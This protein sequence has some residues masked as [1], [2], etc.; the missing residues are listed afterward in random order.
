MAFQNIIME[1]R[2]CGAAVSIDPKL[3]FATCPYCGNSNTMIQTDRTA[4]QLAVEEVYP[5][6]FSER[7]FRSAVRSFLCTR[8][9]VPDALYETLLERE[10]SL[11]FWPFYRH[12][13]QW[14]ANW[15]ADVGYENEHAKQGIMWQA[16][17]G[18]AVGTAI[19]YAPGSSVI[20]SRG[21]GSAGC[22]LAAANPDE[23]MQFHP[24]VFTGISYLNCDIEAPSMEKQYVTPVLNK[25]IKAGCERQLPGEYK[26]NM[27]CSGRAD[28]RRTV[29]Q[30]IPFWLFVYDWEGQTYYVMQNAA[31][32]AVDGTLPTTSRRKW[33]AA[34]LTIAAVA[35]IALVSWGTWQAKGFYD[36]IFIV[37]LTSPLAAAGV[38]YRDIITSKKSKLKLAPVSDIGS[39][40]KK[41]KNFE[42]IFL[43]LAGIVMA[44]W[45]GLAL[46][47]TLS[48]PVLLPKFWHDPVA[49]KPPE[50]PR[51]DLKEKKLIRLKKRKVENIKSEV[52]DEDGN[53]FVIEK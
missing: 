45:I 47:L 43:S 26:K 40:L 32:G 2:G 44:G 20:H 41:L 29:L 35:L 12:E 5:A 7:A 4:E 33:F 10:L 21:F 28:G 34:L 23:P 9:D 36:T 39:C 1:C 46:M 53:I 13:I 30:M 15:T 8:P 11:N 17:S 27:R 24:D 16:S 19:I 51:L 37:V 18:Q 14:T 6:A 49:L 48:M 42:K 38:V 25:E 52:S 22:E 50:P 31:S 3:R